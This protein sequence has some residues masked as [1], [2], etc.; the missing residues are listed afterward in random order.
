MSVYGRNHF[1]NQY[2]KNIYSRHWR[3][4]KEWFLDRTPEASRYSRILTGTSQMLQN[5][6]L[7]RE[8]SD[9]FALDDPLPAITEIRQIAA[10]LSRRLRVTRD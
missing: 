9:T 7:L 5:L 3:L 10:D 6:V 2:R 4:D 8:R 1:D